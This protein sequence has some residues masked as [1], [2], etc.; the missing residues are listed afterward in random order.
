M[1]L[2]DKVAVIYGAGAIGSITARVFAREGAKV[3]VAGRTRAKL[4]ALASDI[5]A[6][7]G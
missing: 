2:R 1:L 4:E 7:G 6:A 3:Y 5:K